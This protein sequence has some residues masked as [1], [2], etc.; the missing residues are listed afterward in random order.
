MIRRNAARATALAAAL[1]AM[2]ACNSDDHNNEPLD[3]T[4]LHINDHH[5]HLDEH[6]FGLDVSDL[7]LSITPDA[8]K[9]EVRYGGYPRMIGLVEE[10]TGES[11]NVLKL[12]AGDAITGTLYYTLFEGE[13]DA[14]MMNRICFDA[15]TVGNH[16]FDDSDAGLARFIDYLHS[17]TCQ[18]P[19][20]GANVV[21]ANDSPIR[22]RI[23][24]YTIVERSGQK[25]GVIGIDIAGK[26]KNSSRPLPGTEFLDETATAQKYIDELAARGVDK[27][28]LLTHY[29]YGNETTLAQNLRGVDVVVGGDSHTL[30]GADNLMGLGFEPE[31]PYPTVVTNADGDTACVVQAWEYTQVLGRLDVSFDENG[32]VIECSG[33]PVMPIDGASFTAELGGEE[34]TLNAADQAVVLERLTAL[35]E[36]RAVASDSTAT[37]LLAGYDEQVDVLKQTVIGQVAENLCLA[38]IPGDNRGAPLCEPSETYER[39][40]DISNIVAKAFLMKEPSADMAIQNGG[41]VGIIN[42]PA[43]DFTIADA[44]ALLP[45]ANNM[46]VLTMTGAEIIEVLEDALANIYDNG[47]STGAYPYASG[48]RYHVDASRARG[49]RISQVEVNPRL[50]GDWQPIDTTRSYRVVTH[51]FISNGRDGYATFGRIT[52]DGRSE[53]TYS[54]YAQSFVD[55]VKSL[56]EQGQALRKLPQ[57]EY[58][59]QQFTDTSGCNHSQNPSC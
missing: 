40:S 28:I 34:V 50:T 16:E 5:S 6:D 7:P 9:V 2:V 43:G 19:V 35:P 47:G 20:L 27:I 23:S 54:E 11:A 29:Q 38:R 1:A 42:I 31:G 15:F 12:H 21:P 45:F 18:T 53:D 8:G 37:S 57:D 13:A 25:L 26:T 41:G 58:S 51:D 30:L 22:D 59:T 17:G 39:G 33:S 36:V 46:V 52:E 56:T 55:Y 4:I 10:L 14:A 24:P 48:L 3:V 49:Q 32:K 44:Y